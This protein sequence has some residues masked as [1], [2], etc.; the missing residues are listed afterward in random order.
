VFLGRHTP[1]L[2]GLR[3]VEFLTPGFSDTLQNV[4]CL[5]KANFKAFYAGKNSRGKKSPKFS[6]LKFWIFN[7]GCANQGYH[8]WIQLD[9]IFWPIWF[10]NCLK[11][12]ANFNFGTHIIFIGHIVFFESN[13]W[14]DA[15]FWGAG[16][17]PI[18]SSFRIYQVFYCLI[19]F[20]FV[21]FTKFI[22]IRFLKSTLR[23]FQT[24][25]KFQF[26]WHIYNF[27]VFEDLEW[28]EDDK[29]I[30]SHNW[31]SFLTRCVCL[32]CWFEAKNAPEKA[33]FEE[34]IEILGQNWCFFSWSSNFEVWG[35]QP[36][37]HI[38]KIWCKFLLF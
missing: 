3:C 24:S 2:T 10:S 4:C 32:L 17:S 33:F 11:N 21:R 6:I 38:L 15:K 37:N 31:L 14:K 26:D 35:L 8:Y 27:D 30:G 7:G 1:L 28:K 29:N 22:E 19:L 20:Q 9:T 13:H 23:K 34:K 16:C 12:L 25:A 5:T 18:W 36:E